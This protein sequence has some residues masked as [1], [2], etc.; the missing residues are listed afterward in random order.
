MVAIF[1]IKQHC[2]IISKAPNW[3]SSIIFILIPFFMTGLSLLLT[4]FLSTD[5][6]EGNVKDI[7]EANN[8]YLPS[9][10]GYFFVALS[11]PDTETIVFVFF[12][13]VCIYIFFTNSLF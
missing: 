10:L 3:L 9:Y 6:I 2:I 1:L 12:D 8:A 13:F 5:S 11:V 7:E 4:N